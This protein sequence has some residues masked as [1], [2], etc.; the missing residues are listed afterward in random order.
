MERDDPRIV[1]RHAYL[2]EIDPLYCDVIAKRWQ[3]YTGRHAM[4]EGG[5]TFQE[6]AVG[7]GAGDD[8]G[9]WTDA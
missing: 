1:I 9:R 8:H 3:D 4:L 7:R 6:V 2:M 5:G